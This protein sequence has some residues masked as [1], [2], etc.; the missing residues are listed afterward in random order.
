MSRL[1]PDDLADRPFSVA[2]ARSVGVSPKRLR[3]SDLS[4]PFWG[5]R[6]SAAREQ[7]LVSLVA[8][9]ATRIPDRAFYS[10]QTAAQLWGI[11]LPPRL[12]AVLPLHISSDA[13]HRG[14]SGRGTVG[15]HVH[16]AARDIKSHHGVRLTSMERTVLDLASALCDEDLLSAL[17]NI[18]WRRRPPGERATPTSIADAFTRFRGRRGRG[19]LLE[20]IPF[21][22]NRSDS[23]PETAF[24][25][26]F[27]QAGFPPALPNL[28]VLDS[29]GQFVALPDLQFEGFRMCFDYEG[30]HHRTDRV[31]W[32]KDIARVPRLQDIGWHHTRLS[33]ADLAHPD[34]SLAR[35]RRLLIERGWS[36]HPLR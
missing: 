9:R 23:S 22:T 3:S 31:Q 34:E 16:I 6:E 35:T 1:L 33:A 32:Q 24:R 5:V 10:H 29:R 26:R 21:A 11:P 27:H 13:D 4:T 17:D 7:N 28:P 15:H 14:P 20:L 8:A 2:E 18:L 36:P 30:D 25:W 19:R 12:D